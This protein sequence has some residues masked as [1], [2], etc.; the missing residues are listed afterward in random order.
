MIDES[1]DSE[2]Y[3]QVTISGYLTDYNEDK[4]YVASLIWA[5]KAASLQ[6]TTYDVSADQADYKYSQKIENAKEMAK[7]YA[8]KRSPTTSQWIKSPSEEDDS[9]TLQ[10]E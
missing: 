6:A 10:V 3:D 8:S 4:N 9:D 5:E 1:L 2:V 7:Y